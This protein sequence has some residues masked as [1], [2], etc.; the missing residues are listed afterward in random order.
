MFNHYFFGGKPAFETFRTFLCQNKGESVV[1]VTDP[2]FGG[3]VEALAHSFKKIVGEWKTSRNKIE[4]E[5]LPIFWIFPY[6]F[7]PRIRQYFP[8]LN[9]LDYQVRS[10]AACSIFSLF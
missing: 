8:T 2:P 7:E 10:F 4:D 6:F 9:M 5:E 3:L 1:M